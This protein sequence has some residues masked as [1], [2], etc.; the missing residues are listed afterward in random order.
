MY[1]G[2]AYLYGEGVAVDYDKAKNF[3]ELAVNQGEP[4]MHVS[5]RYDVFIIKSCCK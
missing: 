1:L 3:L 2:Y 4:S 5:F